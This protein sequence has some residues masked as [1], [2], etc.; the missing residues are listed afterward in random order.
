MMAFMS[1]KT[2]DGIVREHPHMGGGGDETKISSTDFNNSIKGQMTRCRIIYRGGSLM[3]LL[4]H[5]ALSCDP[6]GSLSMTS[7][8]LLPQGIYQ[9]SINILTQVM[10][11]RPAADNVHAQ[12]IKK[13]TPVLLKNLMRDP[14]SPIH[15]AAFFAVIKDF[16]TGANLYEWGV[17]HFQCRTPG[18]CQK[19]CFY[20]SDCLRYCASTALHSES[21]LSTCTNTCSAEGKICDDKC[22]GLFQVDPEIENLRLGRDVGSPHEYVLWPESLI[23]WNYTKVC[24]EEGLGLIGMLGGPDY[25]ALL[26]WLFVG[27][28]DKKCTRFA[29]SSDTYFE[30]VDGQQV[31][32]YRN[33]CKDEGYSWSLDNIALGPQAYQ[34]QQSREDAWKLRYSGYI[35]DSEDMIYGYEHCAVDGYLG[36]NPYGRSEPIPT[37][38]LKASV[39]DYGCKVGVLPPWADANSCD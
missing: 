35:N 38:I 18:M 20:G 32:R 6:H 12:E 36:F 39:L 17:D 29:L 11:S 37:R 30:Q 7:R 22:Y 2:H 8:S 33:P 13:H 3:S 31:T 4:G 21:S 27:E 9:T 16:E 24:G 14:I 28:N 19:K 1:C 10:K 34:Q 26:F 5:R 15:P 23:P 25:C